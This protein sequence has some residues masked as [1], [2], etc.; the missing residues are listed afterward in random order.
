MQ[1]YHIVIQLGVSPSGQR[2]VKHPRVLMI[3]KNG[4]V[5]KLCKISQHQRC[6]S[7]KSQMYKQLLRATWVSKK[8][9]KHSKTHFP[10]ATLTCRLNFS[11]ASKY[12]CSAGLNVRMLAR[13]YDDTGQR[14][15]YN[16]SHNTT[17]EWQASAM[18]WTGGMVTTQDLGAYGSCSIITITPLQ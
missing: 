6:E 1:S 4:E 10:P 13:T 8:S 11:L 14:R 12:F 3:I 5:D 7:G 15:D 9:K 18:V 17:H 2:K 16:D